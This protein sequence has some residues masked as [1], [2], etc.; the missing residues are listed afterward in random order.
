[1]AFVIDLHVDLDLQLVIISILR[2]KKR[3]ALRN[4]QNFF[5]QLLERLSRTLEIIYFEKCLTRVGLE[6][7]TQSYDERT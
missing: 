1:M 2:L 4:T 7:T 6:L 5:P 3:I